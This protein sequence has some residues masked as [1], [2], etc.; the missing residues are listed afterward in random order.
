MRSVVI[1][2]RQKVRKLLKTIHYIH[3]ILLK[4]EKSKIL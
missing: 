1:F 2:S 4:T 3:D